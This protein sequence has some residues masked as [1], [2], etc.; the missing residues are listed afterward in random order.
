MER[1]SRKD[2]GNFMMVEESGGKYGGKNTCVC[3]CVCVC[4]WKSK[5]KHLNSR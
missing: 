5:G 2:G 1:R 4:A 3:V